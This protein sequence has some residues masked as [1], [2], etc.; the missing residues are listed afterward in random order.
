M[1][2]AIAEMDRMT[3]YLAELCKSTAAMLPLLDLQQLLRREDLLPVVPE[4]DE[5]E[6]K[7]LQA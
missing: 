3:P 6:E 4:D 7:P 5:D 1:H 2:N